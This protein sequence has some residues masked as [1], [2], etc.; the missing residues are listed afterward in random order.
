MTTA[1]GDGRRQGGGRAEAFR[2]ST[3]P[4]LC[5]TSMRAQ[6]AEPGSTTAVLMSRSSRPVSRIGSL[7]P[8]SARQRAWFNLFGRPMAGGLS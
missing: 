7:S 2:V 4:R 6:T 1:G 3:T 8:R 5:L